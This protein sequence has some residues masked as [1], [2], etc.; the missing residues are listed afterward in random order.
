MSYVQGD[1]EFTAAAVKQ[2]HDKPEPSKEFRSKPNV[3]H[4]AHHIQQPK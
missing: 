1:K 3:S 2:Y 4:Q